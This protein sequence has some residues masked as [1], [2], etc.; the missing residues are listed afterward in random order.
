MATPPP[1]Y[2]AGPT[3]AKLDTADA[4]DRIFALYR[5][6]FAVLMGTALVIFVP[7]GILSGIVASSGSVFLAFLALGLSLIGS[8]LY[9]GA[10][11]EAVNDMRDGRRDF[12]VGNLLQAASPFIIPLI[13][14]GFLYGVM[15]VVGLILIIVPG[16]VFLTWFCLYP[17]AIVI[18]K[19]GI[20]PAFTRS[21]ELVSGNGWRV[22][23]VL[24]V[25]V[26]IQSVLQNLLQRI[27]LNASD[28]AVVFT[29]VTTIASVITAPI[30]SLAVS[31]MYFQLRDLK[32]GTQGLYAPV[33]PPQV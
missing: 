12:S 16:L 5:T 13:A 19:R 9:T 11:V 33:P 22:F 23:G 29:I 30:I 31:V 3:G 28:S 4:F 17:P 20:F 26:L 24:V 25:A 6:Q 27:A 15:V 21:R 7:I 2:P 14:A 8:A 10:V 18:E 32:E 1:Q